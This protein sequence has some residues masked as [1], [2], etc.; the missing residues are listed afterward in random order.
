MQAPFTSSQWYAV[1]KLHPRLR[2]HVLVRRQRYRDGVSY[3]LD[4]GLHGHM[5]RLNAPAYAVVGRCNG[6]HSVQAIW[7]SLL[8]TAPDQAL[9]QDE[10]I[11]LLI[12]LH[13]LGLLQCERTPDVEQLFRQQSAERRRQR[14]QAINPLSMRLFVVNP[15]R[16]IKRFDALAPRLFNPLML[17]AWCVLV[18]AAGLAAAVH[19][20]ALKAHAAGWL[21]TP[22]GLF[23]SWLAFP[24]VKAVHE[25]AHGLAVRRWGGEVHRA[26]ITL[27]MLTPMPFVDASAASAFRPAHRRFT[28]SAAG[29]LA[30][31]TLAALAMLLWTQIQPGVVRDLALIVATLGSV[32]T[33]VF[34][35]NPLLRFDGYHM[36]SDAIEVPNLHARSSQHWRHLLLRHGLRLA[37]A[38]APPSAHGERAWLIAYAPLSWAYRA[39]LALIITAWIGGWSPPVAVLVGLYSAG[40]LL[41]APAMGLWRA[42]SRSAPS[43]GSQGRAHIA[44]AA[45][46]L[47][48]VLLLGVVPWPFATVAH[49]VI[50]VPEQAQIRAESGGFVTAFTAHDGDP[51]VAG[52]RVAVL[53]DPALQ[54]EASRISQHIVQMETEQHRLML[55]D[56]V[57]AADTSAQLQRLRSDLAAVE[58]RLAQLDIRAAVSGRLSM[59]QQADRAGS[60]VPKGGVMGHIIH[61]EASTVRVAV[62]EHAAALLNT[63][64]RAITARLAEAPDVALAAVRTNTSTAA[65]QRLPSAALADRSNGPHV[66]DPSDPQHLNTRE[67]VFLVDLTLPDADAHGVGGRTGGRVW[68]RFEH[69]ATPLALQWG[70]QLQQLFLRSFKPGG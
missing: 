39:A 48:L 40:T 62:S 14:L 61:R 49:G 41:V 46:A 64:T 30:E 70:R 28:V 15:S 60:Y 25:L 44:L 13:Q 34:N 54:V 1:A 38:T 52:Q 18:M 26:G 67:P 56:P 19:W 21:L 53:S 58:Q 23:L 7:D 5:H 51:V 68:V 17:A 35:G 42:L 36:L 55:S 24:V 33:L 32:S 4:D 66:V 43:T 9:T 3:L 20:P 10:L 65:S 57:G 37:D 45:W 63:D 16:F 2:S 31:L 59:P 47:A 11:A 69:S 8:D 50:W 22:Q 27:M 6:R 29:I 12:Q